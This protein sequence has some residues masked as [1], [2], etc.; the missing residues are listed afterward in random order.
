MSGQEPPRPIERQS[1]ADAARATTRGDEPSIS[2]VV[3]AYQAQGTLAPCL[4]SL[5]AQTMDGQTY[6]VIVVDDGSRDGTANVARESGAHV[7]RQRHSGPAA[8]RNR[9]AQEARGRILLFTDADCEPAPDWIERMSEQFRDPRVAGVKGVYRSRQREL[10]ARFVQLEYE[11][12]YARMSRLEWIDFVDTYSAGYRRAVFRE[13]DGFDSVF[14]DASVEDQELSFRLARKGYLL[15]FAPLAAVYHRH[16]IS[17]GQY[18]RRKYGIGYWKALLL[19]WH[20]ER[21]ANDSHTPQT[22]KVQIVMVGLLLV[23]VPAAILWSSARWAAAS[24]AAL[25]VVAALPFMWRIARHDPAVALVSPAFIF[26]RAASLGAGLAA[27]LVGLSRRISPRRAPISAAGRLVKRAIDVVGSLLGLV[28]TGPLIALLAVAISLDTPGPVFHICERAGERGRPFRLIKLRTSRVDERRAPGKG[29]GRRS[30]TQ[31][32]RD[33]AGDRTITG[34]GRLLRRFRL[35][36]LPQLWNVLKG[37]MSLV[38]PLPQET[39]VVQHYE[40]RQRLRLAVRPGMTGPAQVEGHSQMS[41]A[42]QAQLELGYVQNYT[43]WRDLCIL[44]RTIGAAIAGRG[45]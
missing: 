9:G 8:A 25:F 40:D 15:R 30:I 28:L 44:G 38:G 11:H 39:H 24:V 16:D 18:V 37:E 43:L 14:P 3:P 32:A 34:V 17:L 31:P 23:L 26:C 6:E 13:N 41:L 1:L 22:L 20:P 7:I 27:G 36:A 5:C 12:K 10:T 29:T 35:D 45:C 4:A 33:P 19:R 21:V 2:V 42:Q